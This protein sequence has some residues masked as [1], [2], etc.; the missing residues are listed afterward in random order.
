MNQH[1]G[2][3]RNYGRI[4][5]AL[6][7]IM[8][9]RRERPDLKDIARHLS[10][11]EYHFQRLFTGWVGISPK[12]FLQYLTVEHAKSLIRESRSML[13]AALDSGLSG[14]GRLHDLFISYEAMTPGDF[15]K[16]GRGIEIF[17]GFYPSPFGEYLLSVTG[18]GICG[19]SFLMDG[20]RESA[21][22]EMAALWPESDFYERKEQ[23]GIYSDYI[24]KEF[25][26][27][28]KERQRY[29]L[30][31]TPFQVKVWQALLKIPYGTAVTYGD[32]ALMI[33]MPGSARAVAG[34]VASNSIAFLIPCHRVITSLGEVSGYRWGRERKA[35]LLGW[36]AARRNRHG[37][38]AD[39]GKSSP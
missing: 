14:P 30:K 34:A 6:R 9:K 1:G 5:T 38:D 17:Y 8:E 35:A 26:H 7:Y 20:N 25:F 36:E 24:A 28:N 37:D 19:I 4:E 16:R 22:R 10:M 3:W 39:N 2:M 12:K 11:S 21:L 29:I 15:K 32:I 13:D 23:T 18:K 33:G 27:E 31:G